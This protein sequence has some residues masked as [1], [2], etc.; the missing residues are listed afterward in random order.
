MNPVI[1]KEVQG[2]PDH[3]G[4]SVEY[5]TNKLESFE[6]VRH[7]I[8]NDILT[9]MTSE[10]L[11]HWIPINSILNVKFDKRLTKIMELQAKHD[12]GK[13]NTLSSI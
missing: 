11:I 12:Q 2:L 5:L 3:Y 6:I 13:K 8:S 10:E 9:F 4:M 1:L 7:S